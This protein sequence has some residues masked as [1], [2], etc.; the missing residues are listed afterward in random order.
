VVGA[1]RL[2]LSRCNMSSLSPTMRIHIS[3]I[4][5]HQ[6]YCS[7]LRLTPVV[8]CVWQ[9]LVRELAL[10]GLMRESDP[11]VRNLLAEVVNI[12]INFDYPDNWPQLLGKG[13]EER[14]RLQSDLSWRSQSPQS[15]RRLWSEWPRG[16]WFGLVLPYPVADVQCGVSSVTCR[17]GW[18]C[19]R[20]S[21]ATR[22]T[23]TTAYSHSASCAR[24]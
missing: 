16:T 4:I 11:P 15:V 17:Q 23:C 9:A 19:R 22:S 8:L 13:G 3:L 14:R 6:H 7:P 24:R 18:W 10:E 21:R 1:W 20:S 2:C 5:T 12:L